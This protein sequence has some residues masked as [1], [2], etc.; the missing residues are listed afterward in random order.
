ML[1][2]GTRVQ[3]SVM[4]YTI[5]CPTLA[6]VIVETPRLATGHYTVLAD[7][8]VWATSFARE[9]VE[10]NAMTHYE[11]LE[12]RLAVIPRRSARLEAARLNRE[13]QMHLHNLE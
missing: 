7:T 10:N 6:G 1:P 11:L 13:R 12:D 8:I 5:H 4:D 9:E 3:F 2:V